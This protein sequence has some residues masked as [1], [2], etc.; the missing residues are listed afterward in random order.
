MCT[1]AS[2]SANHSPAPSGDVH[3]NEPDADQARAGNRQQKADRDEKRHEVDR[4][5]VEDR[6]DDDR[7]D[8][9]DDCEGQQE[10]L[11]RGRHTRTEQTH[12]ADRHGDVGRHGDA[13]T[14]CPVPTHVDGDVDERGN[15]HAADG[16]DGRQRGGARITQ[17]AL[18]QLPFDLQPDH[19]EED[20]HEPLVHPLFE[21]EVDRMAAERDRQ[22]RVPQLEVGLLPRR[23][24]PDEG[25][26]RRDDEDDSA[27]TL[28]M[29]EVA[30][31]A[32]G[33]AA[34]RHADWRNL[35]RWIFPVAV[36]GSVSIST[37]LLGRLNPASRFR[38]CSI[39]SDS[40]TVAPGFATT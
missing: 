37:T 11:E 26:D 33:D 9:V 40:V 10:E 13:P 30:E 19:E 27:R 5:R 3:E 21:R 22:M 32:D 35:N 24:R 38:Q 6:D 18:D 12:D 28:R 4:V 23:V 7:A 14:P 39:T 8:V 29:E 15:D 2:W 20:R 34:R 36:F 25:G 31:G 17:L 16:S 1:P